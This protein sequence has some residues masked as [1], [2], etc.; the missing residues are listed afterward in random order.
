MGSVFGPFDEGPSQYDIVQDLNVTTKIDSLGTVANVGPLTQSVTDLTTQFNLFKLET[1]TDIALIDNSINTLNANKLNTNSFNNQVVYQDG[2]DLAQNARLLALEANNPNI[3]DLVSLTDFNN[4]Q[5]LQNII[6]NQK[7]SGVDFQNLLNDFLT[8]ETNTTAELNLIDS[9]IVDLQNTK[10]TTAVYNNDKI[11]QDQAIASKVNITTFNNQ[12]TSQ[13]STDL[14]QDLILQNLQTQINSLSLTGGEVSNLTY[15][16]GQATQD[17][18]I[19]LRLRTSDFIVERDNL[20]LDINQRALTSDLD[21][22]I[23]NLQNDINSNTS[24]ING[25]NLA[26][27]NKVSNST[28]V[29]VVDDINALLNTKVNTTTYDGFVNAVISEQTNINNRVDQL[30]QDVITITNQTT[31]IY[32]LINDKLSTSDFT[33][34]TNGQT[35]INAN[36]QTQLNTFSSDILSVSG[37]ANTNASNISSLTSIVTNQ[38]A[39]II[40]LENRPYPQTANQTPYT[41]IPGISGFLTVQSALSNLQANINNIVTTNSGFATPITQF[42]NNMGNSYLGNGLIYNLLGGVGANNLQSRAWYHLARLD[43]DLSVTRT[44]PVAFNRLSLTSA[45]TGLSDFNTAKILNILGNSTGNSDSSIFSIYK[46]GNI[47]CDD[48]FIIGGPTVEQ[49]SL[50][51]SALRVNSSNFLQ[52]IDTGNSVNFN[53]LTILGRNDRLNQ[54]NLLKFPNLTSDG[55]LLI[56]GNNLQINSDGDTESRVNIKKD[57]SIQL[58]GDQRADSN[59]PSFNVARNGD[60]LVRDLTT[61]GNITIPTDRRLNTPDITVYTDILLAGR[62]I[63]DRIAEMKFAYRDNERILLSGRFTITDGSYN[64]IP[65]II[66]NTGTTG[67]HSSNFWADTNPYGYLQAPFGGLIPVFIGGIPTVNI[68]YNTI[69]KELNGSVV[70]GQ[71]NEITRSPSAPSFIAPNVVIGQGIHMKNLINSPCIGIGTKL[72]FTNNTPLEQSTGSRIGMGFNNRISGTNTFVIGSDNDVQNADGNGNGSAAEDIYVF[73]RNWNTQYTSGTST[74]TSSNSIFLGNAASGEAPKLTIG[75]S[76]FTMLDPGA[77]GLPLGIQTTR[78]TNNPKNTLYIAVSSKKYKKNITDINVNLNDFM[79]LRPV[80]YIYNYDNLLQKD[81][82]KI[83]NLQS[84]FHSDDSTAKTRYGLIAED[85]EE[86]DQFK[87]M[88]IYAENEKNEKEILS[89]D[90]PS[91]IA[92]LIQVNQQMIKKLSDQNQ[93]IEILEN[94]CHL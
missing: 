46:N 64:G 71:F 79:K 33:T 10:L 53:D 68:S 65:D 30:N 83:D 35:V 69:A 2:I 31:N 66:I 90:Y 13:N 51:R 88:V 42:I 16:N 27:N 8:S 25:I 37:L 28:L 15:Q 76:G 4:S 91:I 7:V 73:G 70:L 63:L 40:T 62:S 60:T 22:N 59:N 80:N 94:L 48:K 29:D 67:L 44:T 20:I 23:N 17:T 49:Y 41:A 85:V 54:I 75:G 58:F 47:R 57:G 14:V 50:S 74:N 72:N 43:Q 5:N 1:E 36:T 52:I 19:N 11:F 34:Y 86:I 84:K 45:N 18:Q 81:S 3:T 21:L 77:G 55:L 39:R 26:L 92:Q 61:T 56:R 9:Q 38:D 32:G 78:G 82:E 24:Q 87:H 12:I 6:I 93:R 89:L